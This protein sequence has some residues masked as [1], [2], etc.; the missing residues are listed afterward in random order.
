MPLLSVHVLW[1]ASIPG[2]RVH[3]HSVAGPQSRDGYRTSRKTCR[4]A[5]G[6]SFLLLPEPADLAMLGE[7]CLPQTGFCEADTLL[8]VSSTHLASALQLLLGHGSPDK[9]SSL[10]GSRDR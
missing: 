5:W 8:T 1:F 10:K 3:K 7:R 6:S 2:N 9:L 4:Q